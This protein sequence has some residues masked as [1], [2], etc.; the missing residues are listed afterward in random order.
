[1]PDRPDKKDFFISY[2]KADRAWAEWIAWQL[3]EAGF[4]V[5]FEDW[6]FRAG[7]NF[8]L[9]M[10]RAISQ[11]ERTVAV[12]SEDFLQ[13]VYVHPEWAA[14]FAEDPTGERRTLVPVKVRDCK[15]DGLLRQLIFIDL[16]GVSEDEAKQRL[17][18]GLNRD[19][20]KPA[21]APAFPGATP[22]LPT[23]ERSIAEKPDFPGAFPPVWHIPRPQNPHF[24]GRDELLAEIRQTL[25]AGKAAALTALH[26]MGGVGKTQLAAEYAYA[27]RADYKAV[28]W[29]NSETEAT[30]A[31]DLAAMASALNLP[32][33]DAREIPV[34]VAA[35]LQWL[36]THT[37]WLLIYDNATD[38]AAIRDCLPQARSGHVIVTSRDPNWRGLAEPLEVKV[39]DA[40]SGAQFLLE[41]TGQ[42]DATAALELAKELGGL[43]LALEQAGAYCETTG[44]P[45]AAYLG[46]FK[47]RWQELLRRGKP[48]NYPA[49]VATTWEIS[50]EAAERECP[51]AA[52]LLNLLAF[53]APEEL[54]LSVLRDG[55]NQL[56]QSLWRSGVR[57]WLIRKLNKAEKPPATLAVT[58]ANEIALEDAIAALRRYSLLTRRSDSVTLHRLVQLVA[59]DRLS[60]AEQ[61]RWA[62]A[63]LRLVNEAFPFESEDVRTWDACARLLPHAQAVTDFAEIWQLG[64]GVTSRLV[65]QMGIYF[66]GRAQ[67]AEAKQ[68][69]ERS[70]RLA[71]ATFGLEHLEVAIIVNNLG[72]VLRNLGDWAG[73]RLCYERTLRLAEA[74]SDDSKVATSVNNLGEAL[75]YIGDLA[76]ARQCFERALP[77]AEAASEDS[78]VTIIVNNLGRVQQDLGDLAGARQCFERALHL[79]EVAFGPDHPQAAIYV[80]NLGRVLGPLGDLAGARQCYERAL[81][82]F[83]ARLGAE[84]P[85]TVTVRKNLELLGK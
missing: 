60:E 2:N 4:S 20:A 5:I 54:P 37:G 26:G 68:T 74:A 31:N 83:T 67:Y 42:T 30:M 78:T 23:A 10:H 71:E 79:G 27:H 81:R 36:N 80:N 70:L 75:L 39:L 22:T 35:V 61:P 72:L 65:N 1:M 50:F 9:D 7:G 17:L 48:D 29:L 76:G 56:T 21:T 8:A 15:P 11:S 3:E 64:P 69:L 58:V 6:D 51:A 73:A 18:E 12:L 77:L 85:N 45:L 34:I 28:W 66:N 52:A 40:E 43:P 44:Q 33:K 16:I 84:H 24:V 49:T 82:I 41:R 63:A 55:V 25:L 59:R 53:C 46:L 13:A 38:A 47:Q 19:R 14:A 32:E 62:D 57:G